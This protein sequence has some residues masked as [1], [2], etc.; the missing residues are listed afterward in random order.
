MALKKI[1]KCEKKYF[2]NSDSDFIIKKITHNNSYIKIKQ[3]EGSKENICLLVTME[4]LDT[5]EIFS[6]EKYYFK[7][8]VNEN[9]E[10]FIKQGY[11][12]LKTL[13]EFKEA[14]DC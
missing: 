6:K 8:S 1:I 3:I 14:E 13:D 5:K 4:D 7:P 10:N 12:Y 2:G 9:S 11:E